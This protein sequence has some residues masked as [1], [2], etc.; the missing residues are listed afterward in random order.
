MRMPPTGERGKVM[1]FNLEQVKT[2]LEMFGGEDAA[3]TVVKNGDE[4]RAYHTD[5]PEEGSVEL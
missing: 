1:E 5:Y 2:L 3:I 4:L